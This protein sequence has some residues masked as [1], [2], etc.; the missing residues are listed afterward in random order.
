MFGGFSYAA[1][2]HLHGQQQVAP[3]VRYSGSPLAFSFGEKN[4]AKSV[5]LAELDG[6]GQVTLTQLRHAGAA[7]AARGARPAR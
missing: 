6:A 2:G 4:H 1:L 5:T 7:A 3:A